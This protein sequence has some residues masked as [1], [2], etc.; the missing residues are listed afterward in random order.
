VFL[1]ANAALSALLVPL[2]VQ[3]LGGAT[4]I[5]LIL[6]AL[7]VGFLLGAPLL[8]L[9]VDRMSIRPLLS[10]AQAMTAAGFAVLVNVTAL[11]L[12]LIA[13][14]VIGTAGSVVLGA[15]RTVC[16]RTI[17][18]SALGRVSAVFGIAEAA[19]TLAGAVLGPVLAQAAGLGVSVNTAA[20]LAIAG[21]VLT[22]LI[23]PSSRTS[24]SSVTRP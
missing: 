6:S 4:A 2:G 19:A 11:P 13:A 7:G 17:P 14:V 3:R 18:G 20:L 23:V 15:P 9:L 16:Q 24:N 1:L 5:G 10:G 21:A 8:R 22:A 12:A